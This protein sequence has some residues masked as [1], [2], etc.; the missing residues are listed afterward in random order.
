MN[1]CLFV[2]DL[3]GK[4][5]RYEALFRLIK[6]E[7]PDFVFIGGDLLPHRGGFRE[8]YSGLNT[9]FVSGFLIPKFTKL[10]QSMD[11]SY[12][13]IFLIP[14]NDDR[15]SE[16]EKITKGENEDLWRNIH[17]RCIVMGK[18]RIYGYA[19]VPPTPFRIK[20]WERFDLKPGKTEGC[21][22]P[23]EGVFS[24][25]MPFDIDTGTIDEDLQAL[26]YDE[27]M[28]FGVFLFHWPP[29]DTFLDQADTGKPTPVPVGSKAIRNLI[30]SR[31]PYITMHGHIH[32][33]ASLSGEWKQTFGR[34]LSFSAAHNGPELSVVRFQLH[35]P[36]SATRILIKA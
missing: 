32:E 24:Q 15:K 33:S 12:P 18:Y 13:E 7:K 27:D 34:T 8:G 17:N 25:E 20:D 6:K 1:T 3:H 19:C 28:S 14:G 22:P 9:D 4:M 10:Q 16:F 26:V 21:I 36:T 11:C 30:E 2:S 35:D 23:P 31:Q 5:S 29:F